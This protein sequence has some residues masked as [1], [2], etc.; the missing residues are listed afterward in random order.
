MYGKEPHECEED[1]LEDILVKKKKI[2]LNEK[3]Y[4]NMIH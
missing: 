4:L 3:K 2:D 1:E